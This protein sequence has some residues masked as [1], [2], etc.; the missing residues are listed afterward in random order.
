DDA[1]RDNHV[2]IATGR[3]GDALLRLVRHVLEADRQGRLDILAL[4][5]RRGA[6]AAAL[7][8]AERLAEELRE[9]VVARAAARGAA[10]APPGAREPA[11]AEA[12]AEA[13]E[14]TLVT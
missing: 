14:I 3:Q 9:D 6:G 10:R 12:E 5:A 13:L 11:R 4:L 2:D 1:L 8:G 7:G